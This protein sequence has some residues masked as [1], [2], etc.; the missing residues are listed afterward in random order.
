LNYIL[1]RNVRLF[2]KSNDLF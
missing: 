1:E 2:V